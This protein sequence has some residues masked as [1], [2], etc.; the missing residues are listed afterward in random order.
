M[1]QQTKQLVLPLIT[2]LI[3][4]ACATQTPAPV[5]NASDT[6]NSTTYSQ[7]QD[8]NPYG[9]T[10]YQPNTAST[11]I[12]TTTNTNYTGNYSAVDQSASYHQVVS[13]DTIYNI[14]KRYN[15]SQEDLRAWNHL[16]GDNINI[17]QTLRVKPQTY[18]TNTAQQTPVNT[19]HHTTHRVVAGDTIYNIAKRYNISQATLK[20]LNNLPNDNIQIGQILNIGTTQANIPN[21]NNETP[22]PPATPQSDNRPITIPAP[23][24]NV[25]G[26]TWQSPL[27]NGKVTSKF[28]TASRSIKLTSSQGQA[29]VAAADGQVIFSGPGPRGYGKLIVIQHSSQFL[30]AYGHNET[31]DVAEMQQ[32]KRGQKIGTLGG[33]GTMLFELRQDGKPIDPSKFIK[34]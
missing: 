16:Q 4:A 1:T 3:L 2:T 22:T 29:V 32:V 8:S 21:T 15:I 30:T 27:P 12:A 25:G 28:T 5:V 20:S 34:F 14:S 9:A 23:T 31:L 10:P 11:P 18:T 17:G 24:A 13:G 6:N 19:S 7:P 33:N 26:I